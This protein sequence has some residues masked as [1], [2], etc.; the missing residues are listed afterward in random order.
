M[1]FAAPAVLAALAALPAIWWLLRL[2]PPRPKSETFPPARIVAEIPDI[3]HTSAQTPWWLTAL[4]LLLAALLIVA[5]AGPIIRSNLTNAPGDGPLLL[6]VD[7]G[8][9]AAENWTGLQDAT[10]AILSVAEANNRPVA[11][12]ATADAAGQI[13]APTRAD[14]IRDRIHSLEP[15][16]FVPAYETLVPQIEALGATT[17]FGGVAWL[18]SGLAYAGAEEFLDVIAGT[19]D[20]PL[21]IYGDT[22]REILGLVPPINEADGLAVTIVRSQTGGIGNGV[23]LARDLRG[24]PIGELPFSF[25]AGD[26]T[27]EARLILPQELR[28]DISRIEIVG[29]QTA[30]AVQLLD[31]RYRRRSIGI[32]SGGLDQPLLS[33][34]YYVARAV[35]PF[36]DIRP[37]TADLDQSI[38]DLIASGVSII[39]LADIGT[40]PAGTDAALAAWIENGGT[41]LR[42]AGPRLAAA[43][44]ELIPAELRLGDRTIGGALSWEEPQLLGAFPQSSPFFGLAIPDDVLIEQQVLAE[45]NAALPDRIWATLADGTPL[46]TAAARGDGQII[47]FHVTGDPSWSNLPLSGLFVEMLRRILVLAD[48]PETAGQTAAA[49]PLAPYRVLDGYGRLGEPGGTAEPIAGRNEE[50]AIGATHPPGFYGDEDGFRAVNLLPASAVLQAMASAN[51]GRADLVAY[52][53]RNPIELR[54]WLFAGAFLLLLVDTIAMLFLAGALSPRRSKIAAI[55]IAFLL[56]PSVPNDASAQQAIRTDDLFALEAANRTA[57]AYVLTGDP[58]SDQISRAG[59]TGLTWVLRQRT[60]FEPPDPIGVNIAADEL[61]F[62]PILYWRITPDAPM[63]DQESMARLDAYMRNGGIVLFDT[64]DQLQ[65]GAANIIQITTAAG[66]RLRLLLDGLDIPPLEPVPGD[67]VLTKTYYILADLPGRFADGDFWVE[68]LPDE[69]AARAANRPIQST[70]GV[71]PIMI[72]SNDLAGAWAIQD[73]GA[74]MFPIVSGDPRQREFAFRAGIN[75]VMYALTGNY[76]ADQ[77]H[78][79]DLLERLGQ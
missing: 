14:E 23:V 68:T 22:G 43:D 44:P 51:L 37:T 5:V 75:I 30:G 18:S 27:I 60:S 28:N 67:H 4:R 6:I 46:V 41:L 58:V 24:R 13:V 3:Q 16:P 11:L 74:F 62:F 32:L 29:R 34:E 73:N 15:Q 39:V 12:V 49:Q 70:D 53:D 79:P 61:A 20:G 36:A 42:F 45:P 69:T 54:P 38:A 19:I 40:L 26:T 56:L 35:A 64:A 71:S 65:R 10:L 77:V 8:W 50:V 47:L 78:V 1:S 21:T 25:E 17:E 72:T 31:D 63:P 59:L 76:K 52:P 48:A 33:A 55:V 66:E 57:L 2:T 7:N 9:A